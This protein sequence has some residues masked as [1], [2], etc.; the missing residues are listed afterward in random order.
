[1]KW[2]TTPCVFDYWTLLHGLEREKKTTTSQ[3]MSPLP[4]FN[5]PNHIHGT[6]STHS[7]TETQS[8][9]PTLTL[10]INV[11]VIIGN[12]S[13]EIKYCTWLWIILS[14]I[15]KSQTWNKGD[16]SVNVT[17]YHFDSYISQKFLK[18]LSFP[19]SRVCGV[20]FDNISIFSLFHVLFLKM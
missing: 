13:E 6:L 7:D 5:S 19:V 2:N 12:V 8:A 15:F 14:H 3:D 10:H 11:I 20:L 9:G 17:R 18:P 1:M 16:S 4:L